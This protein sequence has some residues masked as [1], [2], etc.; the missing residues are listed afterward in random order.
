MFVVKKNVLF[1]SKLNVRLNWPL[2]VFSFFP[3]FYK[4][5]DFQ[6]NEY[7]PP[8]RFLTGGV[9]GLEFLTSVFYVANVRLKGKVSKI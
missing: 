5:A 9:R 8:P 1:L 6:E 4:Y 2:F 7:P 3:S